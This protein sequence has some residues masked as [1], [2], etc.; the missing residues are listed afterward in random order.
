MKINKLH[1]IIDNLLEK[2]ILIKNNMPENVKVKNISMVFKVV[3]IHYIK[4]LT[5]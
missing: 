5:L 3:A 1:H 2:K 4:K